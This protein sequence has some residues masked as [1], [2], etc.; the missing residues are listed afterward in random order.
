M[1]FLSN[2]TLNFIYSTMSKKGNEEL[3]SSAI[4]FAIKNKPCID[5]SSILSFHP[6]TQDKTMYKSDRQLFYKKNI[7]KISDKDHHDY[8]K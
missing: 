8:A 5:Y 3:L 2:Q 6:Q 4:G 7:R 1:I